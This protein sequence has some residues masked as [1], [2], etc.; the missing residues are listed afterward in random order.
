MILDDLLKAFPFCFELWASFEHLKI[1]NKLWIKCIFKQIQL[2]KKKMQRKPKINPWIRCFWKIV[3]TLY[4]KK[5]FC[6]VIRFIVY[7]AQRWF[8][9]DL[10]HHFWIINM[11][12]Y[13]PDDM[14]FSTIERRITL[15]QVRYKLLKPFNLKWIN[16]TVKLY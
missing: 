2:F 4:M 13:L 15:L 12:M 5:S 1:N 16:E 6:C 14:W 9:W 3:Y 11:L 8:M 7:Y 10:L